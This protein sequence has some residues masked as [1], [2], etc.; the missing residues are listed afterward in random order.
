[1]PTRLRFG[2]MTEREGTGRRPSPL[3]PTSPRFAGRGLTAALLLLAGAA[4]A[5]DAGAPD[6]PPVAEAPPTATPA[7]ETPA[8]G[9]PAADAGTAAVEVAALDT[10]FHASERLL[11][12]EQSDLELG[13][14]DGTAAAE[15]LGH[16]VF[17]ENQLRLGGRVARGD[18]ELLLDADVLKGLFTPGGG[19]GVLAP[20]AVPVGAAAPPE[21][22]DPLRNRQWGINPSS[23][24]LRQLLLRWRTRAGVLSV[25]ATTFNFGLGML[26]NSAGTMED[27]GYARQLGDARFGDRVVRASYATKPLELAGLGGKAKNLTAALAADLVLQDATATL[28]RPFEQWGARGAIADRGLGLLLALVYRDTTG[29]AGLLVS[30]RSVFFADTQPLDPV[31]ARAFG[32]DLGVWAFALTADTHLELESGLKLS[33]GFEAAL[34]TGSTNHVRNEACLG[35]TD[36]QR[37]EVLQGGAVARGAMHLGRVTAELLGGFASGDGNP[38]DARVTN[39]RYS[40]DFQAGFVL[41]DQVLAWQSAASVRRASDPLLTNA[42]PAG[43]GLLSTNGAVTNAVFV[44][45]SLKVQ[46]RE[47]LELVLAALWARAPAAVIDPA[48]TTRLG[49]RTNAFGQPAGLGYGLELDAGANFRRR[50]GRVTVHAGLAAGVLL[51]GDAF[52]VEAQKTMDPVHR[53]K[54]RLAVWF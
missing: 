34:V 21:L 6:A 39:Y 4:W 45:P 19:D 42:P 40:R 15:R 23:F 50:F 5:Q 33:G 18:V 11:V 10:A 17:V 37:C 7:P 16:R 26:A 20:A 8:T 1:M 27:P 49:R 12:W 53:V 22:A 2:S 29:E 31:A 35:T 30:R 51:P 52:V 14:R 43:V 41:F 44:A 13:R 25:G 48:W 36:A 28:V 47:D 38:F 54:L 9:T 46:A 3:R 32:T 24:A